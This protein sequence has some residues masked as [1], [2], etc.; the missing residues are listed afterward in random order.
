MLGVVIKIRYSSSANVEIHDL[1]TDISSSIYFIGSEGTSHENVI[2]G[3]INKNF[4]VI[5]QTIYPS[6]Q[7]MYSFEMDSSNIYFMLISSGVQFIVKLGISNGISVNA[8][9]NSDTGQLCNGPG[10]RIIISND[11]N[12]LYASGYGYIDIFNNYKN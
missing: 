12:T 9:S 7:K 5:W 2:L 4:V 11:N 3:K 6:N 1:K 8:I 10:C